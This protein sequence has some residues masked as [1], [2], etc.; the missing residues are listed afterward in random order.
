MTARQYY[1]QPGVMLAPETDPWLQRDYDGSVVELDRLMKHVPRGPVC[2]ECAGGW[3]APTGN[4][5]TEHGIERCDE[6][7]L[8]PSD[9]DAAV[10]LAAR[11]PNVTVWYEHDDEED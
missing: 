2:G 11:L 8:Y 3:F 1:G 5:P 4:G 10:A 6:C 7:D 9:L